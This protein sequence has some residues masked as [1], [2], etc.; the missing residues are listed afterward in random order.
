M[1]ICAALL[2]HGLVNFNLYILEVLIVDYIGRSNLNKLNLRRELLIRE[3]YFYNSVKPS[4]NVAA[5][6]DTFKGE[7]HPNWNKTRSLVVSTQIS[8]TLTGRTPT[9]EAI[10]KHLITHKLKT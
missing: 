3:N 10:V 2:L 6:L 7:N 9:L 5:I 1:P 8:K 4:Y